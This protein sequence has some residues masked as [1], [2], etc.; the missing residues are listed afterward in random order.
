MKIDY[1]IY[2]KLHD[3]SRPAGCVGFTMPHTTSVTYVEL[4]ELIRQ[5]NAI[6]RLM[7]PD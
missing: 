2:A 3:N 7:R 1:T 4:L 6:E 5:L